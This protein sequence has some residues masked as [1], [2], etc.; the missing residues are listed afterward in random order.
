VAG[1]VSSAKRGSERWTF[2]DPTGRPAARTIGRVSAGPKILAIL[3]LPAAVIGYAVGVA[4]LSALPLPEGIADLALLF[5]PLLIAGLCMV[6]FLIPLVD[7]MAKRDLEAHRAA[8]AAAERAP[9]DPDA[10]GD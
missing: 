2:V 3:S 9:A 8:T 1:F 6:P 5:V 4:I 10:P 7:R